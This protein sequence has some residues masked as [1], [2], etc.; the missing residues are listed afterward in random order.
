MSIASGEWWIQ[1]DGFAMF[2][3]G[4]IGDQNHAGMALGT[5]LAQ[6]DIDPEDPNVPEIIAM[7]PLSKEAK[8]YLKKHGVPKNVIEYLDGGDP[9]EYMI[10]HN[11]WIRLVGTNAELWEF[12]EPTLDSLRGGIWEAWDGDAWGDIDPEELDFDVTIEEAKTRRTFDVPF[13]ALM[14]DRMDVESLKRLGAEGEI[15]QAPSAPELRAA[16]A[17]KAARERGVENPFHY[18]TGYISPEG[19]FYEVED[20][21]S[22][23]VSEMSNATERAEASISDDV[24]MNWM[25]KQGWI[26][27]TGDGFEAHSHSSF[28]H[29]K[30]FVSKVSISGNIKPEDWL[31][32]DVKLASKWKR[33]TTTAEIV[34]ESDDWSDMVLHS[35]SAK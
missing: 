16:W 1:E 2:A 31:H 11:G 18:R 3:D 22:F 10:E 27:I 21:E 9:R 35:W 19:D 4:D 23:A 20:H 5:I 28:V 24:A 25:L 13:K 30:D 29:L 6:H 14:E 8:K 12:D 15:V 7:E 17:R 26:R 32:Y 33:G 34:F